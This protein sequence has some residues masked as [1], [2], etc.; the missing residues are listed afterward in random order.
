VQDKT[1][2][3]EIPLPRKRRL[4][5]SGTHP[6]RYE[7]KYKELQPDKYSQDVV[8]VLERGQ[9]PAG[10]HRP[11]LLR[12]VVEILAPQSG[13]I[14]LDATLGY[15]GHALELL[16]RILPGGRLYAIDV[17]PIEL[18]KTES[19]LRALGF[20]EDVLVIRRMNFAGIQ[21]LCADS[22][23][24][25]FDFILADLGVSSMQIDNPLRGF[26]FKSDGPL[27]LRLNPNKGKPASAL[28]LS[29]DERLLADLLVENAD[30]PHAAALAQAF[31]KHINP[32]LTTGILA[33][34]IQ[35]TL[36][37]TLHGLPPD[38]RK[39]EIKK[40]KQ[41]VFQALR[42]A[43]NDELSVLDRFL[44]QLPACLKPGGRAVVLSFHSGEDR[45]V[46]KSFL[47][48]SRSGVYR[49][50]APDPVRP[51]SAERHDNPRCACVKMRWA[52]R[53]HAHNNSREDLGA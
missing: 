43:V 32:I 26:S 7:E 8:K 17:D 6:R 31:K 41:R 21:R 10:M 53:S 23:E 4:R 14:G 22:G 11:V 35:Q 34:L 38:L 36:E 40:S 37:K 47:S 13:E 48:G 2:M 33:S 39:E 29:A 27:D 18:P 3:D 45:R 49:Q 28:L 46:K 42:I 12:E 16:K 5:Y 19:R 44:E 20:S 9:T 24:Q 15:G 30:E 50:I 52:I 51:S 25:S 1:L